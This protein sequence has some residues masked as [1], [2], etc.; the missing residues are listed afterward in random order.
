MTSSRWSEKKAAALA[1]T[2]I[3]E[4]I[5]QTVALKRQGK[6]YVG[7]CPFHEEK[8]P[9]FHVSPA[10]KF[11]YCFGCRAKGNAID[12]IMQR[13]RLSFIE[14]IAALDGRRSAGPARP[15]RAPKPMPPA[16]P[17]AAPP[18]PSFANLAICYAWRVTE[19]K[20]DELASALGVSAASLRRLN[21]GLAAGTDRRFCMKC[22][23]QRDAWLFPMTDARGQTHGIRLR[24]IGC[25]HKSSISGGHEGL[26]IPTGIGNPRG[27]NGTIDRLVVC[28]GPTDTAAMLDLGLE[29]GAAVGRPS[30][31]GGARLV[32]DLIQVR[33]VRELVIIADA[34]GPG[35]KGAAAL[36]DLTY[37]LCPRGV[38]VITPQG[39]KDAREWKKRGATAAD[40]ER[41][42]SETAPRQMRG[43]VEIRKGRRACR[44][45]I[46]I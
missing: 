11:F 10:K 36:A 35:Q 16:L 28:E 15:A 5:G 30:C 29:G 14:A 3:V 24:F 44:T 1:S 33:G 7:L 4:L 31:L 18:D 32:L 12:F 41:L 39:A 26:F 13:E 46:Q 21:I 6:D 38:R 23:A 20:L 40:L 9:S 43:A 19:T 17:S 8:T 2:N 45:T 42:I 27:P 34:D 22:Y 37:P 25:S